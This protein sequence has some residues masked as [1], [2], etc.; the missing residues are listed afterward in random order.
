MYQEQT[1]VLTY[2]TYLSHFTACIQLLFDAK[3]T[4]TLL[5]DWLL[6]QQTLWKQAVPHCCSPSE[7]LLAQQSAH[8]EWLILW[9]PLSW[10]SISD[11][12]EVFSLHCLLKGAEV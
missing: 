5:Q 12:W 9:Q 6:R 7:K 8:G 4:H 3:H 2:F 1:A 10:D 11:A